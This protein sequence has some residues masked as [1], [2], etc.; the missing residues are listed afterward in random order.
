MKK[1]YSIFTLALAFALFFSL[2]VS[3]AQPYYGVIYDE[4]GVLGSEDLS[5]LGEQ[6]L[7]MISEV[8]GIDLRVDVLTEISDDTLEE[9][10]Q[11]I[12]DYYGYGFGNAYNGVSLTLLLRPLDEGYYA[13]PGE[14]GWY[15]YCQVEEKLGDST[16]LTEAINNAIRPHMSAQEWNGEDMEKSAI[17]LTRAISAMNE[18]VLDY[19]LNEGNGIASGRDTDMEAVEMPVTEEAETTE[20]SGEMQAAEQDSVEM[21]YVFDVANLLSY[22]EW[23]E[24]ENRAK[25]LSRI[26][27]C[28]IYFMLLDDYTLYGNGSVYE[29]TYQIYHNN[30]FGVGESRDGIIVLLSMNE[31]DYAMFVYGDYAEYAFDSYGQE[32]LE[33][34]FLGDFGEDD[35]YGGISNYLDACD[36]YLTLAEEGNP[37]R[38]SYWP[39]VALMTGISCLISLIVCFVLMSKMKTVYQKTEA[40]E[41]IAENGI[42][43]TDQYD[44][45]THTT[46]TRT[47]IS[48]ES[49]GS[50]SSS[51]SGG[52]GSGRSGKF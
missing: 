8:T 34:R 44:R 42:H 22:E 31:R 45:Y 40:D 51:E 46:E 17:A 29:T 39:R 19:F 27:N 49:S 26:H 25:E 4:T 36:E 11:W 1:L 14:D 3:A 48:K 7:P 5:I 12:Y 50:S 21:G 9:A 16:E 2:P 23:E 15:V 38:P 10:A 32:K 43:L 18:V 28:G 6:S 13:M 37:L 24:L 47:K 33:E 52:G 41:Y 35:W 30:G 20:A